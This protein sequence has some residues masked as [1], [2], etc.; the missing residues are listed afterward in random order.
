L[1]GAR[2]LVGTKY[3]ADARLRAEYEKEI[4]PRTTAALAKV[5]NEIYGQTKEVVAARRVLDIGAGTGAVTRALRAH[6]GPGQS[7]VEVDQIAVGPQTRVVDVT[8]LGALTA[9]GGPFDLVIAAHVLNEL[10]VAED[11][12]QRAARLSTLVRGWC[13]KL[14]ASGGTLIVIEPALRDTSRM[15]LMVRDQVLAAGLH[16][17]APCF[18]TGPCPA[19]LQER[20][21]CHDN[22]SN[23]SQRRVDFSYLVIRG[24]GDVASDP[25]RFRIVSDPLPEKGRLRLFGCGISGRHPIVRLD[26]NATAANGAMDQLVRGDVARISRTT[27]AQDGLRVDGES[28]VARER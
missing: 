15:L 13:G 28:P 10:Y 5:L 6:F 1:I 24:H 11:V 3:L 12:P 22:A 14:L 27:F 4:A 20:D 7:I 26:R 19:L 8:N 18:F 2:A 25:T 23:G 21:W 9:L 16:V 17:V